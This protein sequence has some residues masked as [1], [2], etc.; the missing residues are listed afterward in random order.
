FESIIKDYKTDNTEI[1]L[2]V[3][4]W[5]G[6]IDFN[7]LKKAGVEF[8]FIRVGGTKGTNGEY[9]LDKKFEQNIKNANEV[10]I[11]VG[12]Y[13]YSYANSNES[14]INDAKWVLELIKG[15]KIDLPIAFDWEDWGNYN[16][17]K[18]S[19]FGLTDMASSFLNIFKEAGYEGILYSSKNYL[20]QI[21]L[22]TDYPIWLAH[23]APKTSYQGNYTFWQICSDG[24]VPGIYGDVD[25]NIHYK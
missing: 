5:Q 13:F 12:I 11:P 7:E 8:V 20:E 3:S 21:W 24:K 14:A 16:F 2:D 9:F 15:Y 17:Y 22:K 18:L 4:E 25:I 6:D 19:F 10:G 23:Y 1:G